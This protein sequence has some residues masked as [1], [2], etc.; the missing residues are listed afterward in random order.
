MYGTPFCNVPSFNTVLNLRHPNLS[1]LKPTFPLAAA[2][3]GKAFA[4]W[5][6]TTKVIPHLIMTRTMPLDDQMLRLRRQAREREEKLGY[7]VRA[8]SLNSPS[9]SRRLCSSRVPIDIDGVKHGSVSRCLPPA[10]HRLVVVSRL[11]R[12]YGVG[13]PRSCCESRGV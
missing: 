6:L 4:A 10:S 2:R 1:T 12:I 5:L 9:L 3:S 8:C 7:R 13:E 11:C